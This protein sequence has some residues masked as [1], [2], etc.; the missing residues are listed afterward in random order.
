[1]YKLRLAKKKEE[2]A[3][4]SSSV[5]K[6]TV[7]HSLCTEANKC[8]NNAN[9]D[10]CSKCFNCHGRPPSCTKIFRSCVQ[11]KILNGKDLSNTI[12]IYCA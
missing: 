6:Q 7:P 8:G 11:P 2:D 12:I 10:F 5:L 1:M 4:T 3:R 9:K